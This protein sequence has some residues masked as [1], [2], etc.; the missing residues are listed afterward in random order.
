MTVEQEITVFE[1]K[2]E[3]LLEESE[4]LS[5]KVNTLCELNNEMNTKLHQMEKT[6]VPYSFA[7]AILS[8]V[9]IV[10]WFL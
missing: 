2:T 9:A 4:A 1:D 5:K 6:L 7:L 10:G 3:K 8:V